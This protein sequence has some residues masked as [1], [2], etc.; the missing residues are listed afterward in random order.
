MDNV[1]ISQLQTLQ[2]LRSKC[3]EISGYYGDIDTAVAALQICSTFGLDNSARLL[4][5]LNNNGIKTNE[6]LLNVINDS[7]LNKSLRVIRNESNEVLCPNCNSKLDNENK[8][9][10]ECGQKLNFEDIFVKKP[11]LFDFENVNNNISE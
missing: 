3:L 4:G 9:C 11:A 6:D 1:I 7:R 8:H 5:T 10:S 2:E